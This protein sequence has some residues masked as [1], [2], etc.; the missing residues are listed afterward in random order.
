MCNKRI[1][2]SPSQAN[3]VEMCNNFTSILQPAAGKCIKEMAITSAHRRRFFLK[4]GRCSYTLFANAPPPDFAEEG[5][6]VAFQQGHFSYVTLKT[7]NRPYFN[8]IN[9]N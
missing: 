3:F 2:K 6:S 8:Q 5:F 7:Q 9:S 1:F 4:V